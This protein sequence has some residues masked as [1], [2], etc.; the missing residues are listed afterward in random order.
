LGRR[1]TKKGQQVSSK[2]DAGRYRENE[3]KQERQKKELDPFML[4]R[5]IHGLQMLEEQSE[6]RLWMNFL[7]SKTSRREI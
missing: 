4:L 1:R 5:M 3:K 6:P 7:S 2:V